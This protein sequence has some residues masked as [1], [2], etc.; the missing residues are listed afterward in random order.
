MFVYYVLGGTIFYVGMI[1]FFV[2]FRYFVEDVTFFDKVCLL[3]L[4]LSTILHSFLMRNERSGGSI[5]FF[6]EVDEED[7]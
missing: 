1:L 7:L 2:S 6:G 3:V 5:S 4:V